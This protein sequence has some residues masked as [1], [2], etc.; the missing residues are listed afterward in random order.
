MLTHTTESPPKRTFLFQFYNINFPKQPEKKEPEKKKELIPVKVKTETPTKEKT[1]T[2]TK[3]KAKVDLSKKQS[4]DLTHKNIK[5]HPDLSYIYI[6]I[7]NDT[8]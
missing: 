4:I 6:H 7:H 1:E 5:E 3:E 2:P 8:N